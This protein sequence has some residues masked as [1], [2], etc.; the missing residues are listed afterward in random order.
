[1]IHGGHGTRGVAPSLET[2]T[3]QVAEI[4][5]PIG[6]RSGGADDFA[7]HHGSTNAVLYEFMVAARTDEKLMRCCRSWG[8]SAKI[9]ATCRALAG[10]RELSGGDIS[11]RGVDDQRLGGAAI[12]RGVPPQPELEEQSGLPCRRR[13]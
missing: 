13:R 2:F 1:M 4:M 7:G 6:R 10:C 9:H 8:S 5:W 12:V 3:K 11:Y